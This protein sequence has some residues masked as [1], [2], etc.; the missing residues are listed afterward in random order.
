[1]GT[2]HKID[3]YTPRFVGKRFDDHALPLELMDDIAALQI[4]TIELAK[5]V[6]FEENPTRKRVPRGFTD[7]ME[8][9]LEAVEP[10]STLLKIALFVV[11][12][13]LF[14]TENIQY[15]EKASEKLINAIQSAEDNEDATEH[16]PEVYLSY[17]N[18]I[19]KKLNP[20]ESI[21]F[22]PFEATKKARLTKKSRKRLLL[23]ATRNKEYTDEVELRGFVSEMDKSKKTF[24]IQLFNG[25]KVTG[26]FSKQNIETLQLAFNE[27]ESKRLIKIQGI[28]K[29]N[30][31]DKLE[32]I[33][34]VD[35]TEIL[36]ELDV[37][38]RIEI[39]SL[40]KDGWLNG[41]GIAPQKNLLKWFANSFEHNFSPDLPL[42]NI[43][44]TPDGNIQAEWVFENQ[45][46][47]LLIDL[48]AKTSTLSLLNLSTETDVDYTLNL[49]DISDWESL[50]K[51]LKN[52]IAA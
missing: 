45:D 7:G 42:P 12:S 16:L 41:E 15:F 14:P 8:I 34:S 47:S 43:Y 17:F 18:R 5:W 29:Y 9:K 1:M 51:E 52:L 31:S 46:I 2:N 20:D 32:F 4:L 49:N 50:N 37:T 48:E 22:K 23:A 35:G 25:N 3:I 38:S 40:L 24:Q 39:I 11:S 19:G 30:N 33:E 36:D 27:Y 44:P 28:G 13:N 10:G 6:Y 21:E 26:N